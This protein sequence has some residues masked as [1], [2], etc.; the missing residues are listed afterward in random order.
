MTSYQIED[1]I[2]SLTRQM[3][4]YSKAPRK[5][6]KEYAKLNRELIEAK[7]QEEQEEVGA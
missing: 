3:A 2:N 6:E 7:K 4:C 1:A 5:M